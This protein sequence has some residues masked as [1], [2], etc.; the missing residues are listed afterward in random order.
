MNIVK[1]L[2]VDDDPKIAEIHRRFT[3]KAEG[4]EVVG[5]ATSINEA[6]ELLD[7]LE[8]DLILL[9]IFFPQGNGIDFLW[10]I[11]SRK[12]PVD[13]ILITAAKEIETLH[14]AMRG[15]VFDYIIKPALLSRFQATLK[16]Y[17]STR[18]QLV[19]SGTIDQQ[20]ADQIMKVT[21][22]E[23]AV[24]AALP[25]GIDA[26]SLAKVRKVF[27]DHPK[28]RMSADQVG[29]KIGMSRS[30]ARRYLEYLVD[31]GWLGADISYGIVGRPERNF[32]KL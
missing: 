4:Y 8:P 25:K 6:R 30:S 15:G 20:A 10:E 5:I 12:K 24:P 21:A 11:R 7:I 17:R 27:T 9:D 26:I 18:E 31:A 14:E 16:R 13:I 23:T 32:Y 22:V 2:I 29:I 28:S 3:L 1:A 19:T